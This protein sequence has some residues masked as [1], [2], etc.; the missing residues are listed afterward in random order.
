MKMLIDL[1]IALEISWQFGFFYCKE[2]IKSKMA[3]IF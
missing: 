1:V 2:L 3:D